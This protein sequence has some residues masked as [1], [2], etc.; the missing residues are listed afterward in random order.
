MSYDNSY[1]GNN[2]NAISQ[3]GNAIS[4]GK[5]S[6]TISARIGERNV[7]NSANWFWRA[8]RW[9]VDNTFY[10]VDGEF[11]TF[12]AYASDETED[13]LFNKGSWW[14]LVVMTIFLVVV[15]GLLAPI[16]WTYQLFKKK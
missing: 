7:G 3:L 12:R 11:H 13:F 9:I 6:I 2:L 14:G 10:P 1:L 4:G 5:S 15:C 16:F 8:C